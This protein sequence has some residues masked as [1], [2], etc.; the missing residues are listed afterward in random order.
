MNVFCADNLIRARIEEKKSRVDP[1]STA[2]HINRRS[3][4][5]DQIN[6]IDNLSR[7]SAVVSAVITKICDDIGRGNIVIGN[8]ADVS[9][10]NDF[11]LRN[12]FNDQELALKELGREFIRSILL[13]RMAIL[14]IPKKEVMFVGN[15]PEYEIEFERQ[16]SGTR[17]YYACN[18]SSNERI[19]QHEPQYFIVIVNEPCYDG[20]LDSPVT[21]LVN[22]YALLLLRRAMSL[23]ANLSNLVPMVYAVKEEKTKADPPEVSM[24]TI[25]NEALEM[26]KQKERERQLEEIKRAGVYTMN[27]LDAPFK[28]NDALS[29]VISASTSKGA[30]E[31][32]TDCLQSKTFKSL[33]VVELPDNQK[34]IAAGRPDEIKWTEDVDH[35]VQTVALVLGYPIDFMGSMYTRVSAVAANSKDTRTDCIKTN[36]RILER[37]IEFI[38]NEDYNRTIDRFMKNDSDAPTL[39]I[40]AGADIE[41]DETG[42]VSL[43]LHS[44]PI[45]QTA[46]ADDDGS[47]PSNS[48]E[49]T[50]KRKIGTH[51]LVSNDFGSGKNSSD[52]K[53]VYITFP[54]PME[55]LM[56]LDQTGRISGATMTR[57]LAA[58]LGGDPSWFNE[59]PVLPVPPAPAGG[60][61]GGAKK[62]AS[63]AHK[64]P[65]TTS[66]KASMGSYDTEDSSFGS[67]PFPAYPV[68]PPSAH[69]FY[70]PYPR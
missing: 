27:S 8:A 30:L 24:L 11:R 57:M 32:L 62:P 22:E 21:S 31:K 51:I 53:H 33:T 19:Y 58:N 64:R 28:L 41:S 52:R 4:S 18:S 23:T 37:F 12:E 43:P 47:G 17:I 9:N 48:D 49:G 44:A 70:F 35:F 34:L 69:P 20:K 29:Q 55:E 39:P 7:N 54:I 42:T 66:V 16:V 6:D 2:R 26:Q 40:N 38:I 59:T 10:H 67:A 3:I 50:R 36:I 63:A 13:Y 14:A 68:T 25:G 56:A 45:D 15:L 46:E 5:R 65:K 61:F 60:G 1:T